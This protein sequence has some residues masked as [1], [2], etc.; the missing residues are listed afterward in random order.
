MPCTQG[1]GQEAEAEG[2]RG[3]PETP[4][5]AGVVGGVVVGQKPMGWVL[6][7]CKLS[8]GPPWINQS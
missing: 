2:G 8:V 3:S 5:A 4:E 1:Q 6:T 7:S